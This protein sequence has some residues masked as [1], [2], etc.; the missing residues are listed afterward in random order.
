MISRGAW[1]VK[2]D[3]LKG[4]LRL[5]LHWQALQLKE[6]E[7]DTLI[8]KCEIMFLKVAKHGWPRRWCQLVMAFW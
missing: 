4:S 3:R 2:V 1:D 7:K 6:N 8:L 5:L